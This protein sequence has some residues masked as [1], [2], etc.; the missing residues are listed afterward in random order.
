MQP[1]AQEE[2]E[3]VWLQEMVR[4]SPTFQYW[5]TILRLELLVLLFVR[6]H[7]EADFSLYVSSLKALA[8]W[9][10]AL[11]HPNYA[12]WVPVHIQD[13]ENLPPSTLKEFV[14]HGH[15]VVSKTANKFSGMPLD[16]AHKQ[17]NDLV[18]GS[19]GAVG[20]TENPSALRKW[21]LAGPEQ[22]RMLTEFEDSSRVSSAKHA[23]HEE[24]LSTQECFKQQ[25]L[26][27][28]KV[29]R[30]M[31]NPFLTDTEELLTL[32]SHDVLNDSVIHTVRTI[33]DLGEHQYN[34]YCKSVLT[35]CERSIHDPIQKNSL[36][37]ENY[38]LERN[39]IY[40]HV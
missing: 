12:R 2:S 10:F 23:H 36:T 30:E 39:L 4:K 31:G 6:A 26:S 9:F 21:V 27:L 33:E 17:N 32:D 18:K 3:E 24:G 16:Q 37:K 40:S 35:D 29:F 34:D 11:D 15:W 5:N 22:A 14:E 13:M 28:T 19:G 25:T 1:E 20:L 7:R 38:V 8:K